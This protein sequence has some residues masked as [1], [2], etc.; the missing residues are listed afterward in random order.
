[1]YEVVIAYCAIGSLTLWLIIYPLIAVFCNARKS[2]HKR[3]S[4]QFNRWE[5]RREIWDRLY[6]PVLFLIILAW[7][8]L[9]LFQK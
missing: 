7:I 2:M 4:V 5:H 6:H 1:M 3:D 9:G 8:V